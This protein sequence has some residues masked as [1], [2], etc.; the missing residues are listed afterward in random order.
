MFNNFWFFK[1]LAVCDKVEKYSRAGQATD[2]NE[3]WHVHC[4][5]D[6]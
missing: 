1:N 2:G 5:L 6:T 4:M 3:M